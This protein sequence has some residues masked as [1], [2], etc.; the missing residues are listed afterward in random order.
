M[1]D[2]KITTPA[3]LAYALLN[4][5]D[6]GNLPGSPI[7][8]HGEEIWLHTTGQVEGWLRAHL[9]KAGLIEPVED[10]WEPVSEPAAEEV[11]SRG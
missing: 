1:A 5:L 9:E 7:R 10:N 3:Q 6:D 8:Y 2:P 11:A 4:D